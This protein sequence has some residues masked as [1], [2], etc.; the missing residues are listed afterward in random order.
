MQR[1]AYECERKTKG[2]GGEKIEEGGKNEEE[3]CRRK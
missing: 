2:G 3:G 1:L